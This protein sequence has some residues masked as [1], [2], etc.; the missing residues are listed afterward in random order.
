VPLS[1][2]LPTAPKNAGLP[3]T[4]GERVFEGIGV[5]PGVTIGPAYLFEAGAWQAERVEVD[6]S[7]VDDE[8]NRFERAIS[9]SERELRKIVT[10]AEEKLGAESARIFDAQELM[11]RDPVFYEA[12]VNRIRS[13]H[14]VAG[15]AV[16]SVLDRIRDRV[17][18][19]DDPAVRERAA[20]FDDVRNRVLRN[21]QQGRAV[22]RIEPDR[23]VV[24]RSLTAADDV[25][26]SRRGVLGLVLDF[27][28]PTSHFAI[29]SRALGVPAVVSLHG[30]RDSVH[31]GDT[32]ILDGLSGRVIVRPTEDT[33]ARYRAKQARYEALRDEI[34]AAP[35]VEATA[36]GHP[37]SLQANVEFREELPLLQT[38]GAD[39]IGLFRTEMLFLAQGRALN[40][41]QQ[42]EVY[43]EAVRAAA[44]Y[45]VTFRL[46]DLGGD[47][48]LPLAHREPNPFLGWRGVRILL[49]K[50][51]LLRPQLRAMLRASAE[52]PVRLL[53]PMVTELGELRA[54]R[55]AVKVLCAELEA[56]GIAHDPNVPVGVMV[57]VPAVALLADR[58]AAEADFFSVGTNDLTQFTLGVD[59]G[60]DLVASRYRELHPAVL[61][62]LD[63]TVRAAHEAGI[64]VSLCGEL[65]GDPRATALL[66][67]LGFDALS[68]SPAYLGLAR[69]VLTSL[70]LPD[71]QALA[72]QALAAH[73]AA[74]V[75][76]LLAAWLHEHTPDLAAVL[77]GDP[78]APDPLSLDDV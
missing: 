67:G 58:F 6:G 37:V 32:I 74:E 22:S 2:L 53:I 21:L 7:A 33:L 66:V 23:V 40:E 59:R 38:F 28:G 31:T 5:A 29:M 45:P 30:M 9:R 47:K 1:S 20:D 39:G 3:L 17:V 10:V 55:A 65:A 11:L 19:A 12:V 50:P 56:E 26:F 75:S 4:E 48:V 13:E 16:Q 73:D 70:T 63:R 27:G 77:T 43:R 44:P 49:D 69:R 76:A 52:G 64:T 62:L 14:V 25:L 36:D 68:A 54:I 72:Q 41:E 46:I 61:C 60:N 24:A 71:A 35:D 34:H 15:Y 51:D 57:E 78:I 42:L 8:I 18:G